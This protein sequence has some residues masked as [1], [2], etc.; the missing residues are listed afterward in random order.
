[1]KCHRQKVSLTVFF[2]LL[3]FFTGSSQAAGQ[4]EHTA[5]LVE[6]AKKEGELV[7]YTVMG[8]SDAKLMLDAFKKK[9]PFV[10]TQLFRANG[11]RTLNR[12]MTETRA[13]QWRFDLV[14]V[15]ETAILVRNKLLSRYVSPEAT[16]YI[17]EFK[18]KDSHWTGIFANYYVIGY[19]TEIVPAAEAP[20]Q[21]E[22]LVDPKWKG[23]IGIDREEYPWYATLI[24]SWG[25][26]KTQKYMKALAKQDIHWRRGHTLIA[27]LMAAGEFP[28]AIVYAHR[29]EEMKGKGAPVEW[30]N[31]LDPIVVGVNG[32]SLSAKPNN[33]NTAKLFID[34][35]LSKG[36]QKMI[37]SFKRISTRSDIEPLSPKLD[38]TKLKLKV[39]PA[40][41]ATRYNE[42]VQEFRTLFGL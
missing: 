6:G 23:K 1:M 17:P 35:M 34:F 25:K 30:V 32:I 31:T 4:S 24:A 14:A 22:D 41:T 7:W 29:I 33:P 16:A 20:K 37:R 11:E 39:I 36:A 27:Q 15:S 19:N 40:D 38:Q 8:I 13:G 9:Y 5:R 26:E 42:Y 12:V 3:L 2:C 28:V 10:R 18:D 21:W